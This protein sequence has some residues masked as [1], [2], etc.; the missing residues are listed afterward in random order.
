ML[1]ERPAA[2]KFEESSAKADD[3]F[4]CRNNSVL[5]RLLR[6]DREHPQDFAQERSECAPTK[7]FAKGLALRPLDHFANCTAC[8]KM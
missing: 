8:M 4:L 3:S 7:T 6:G 5:L 1:P 2:E